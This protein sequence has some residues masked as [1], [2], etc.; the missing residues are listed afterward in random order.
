[1]TFDFCEFGETFTITGLK[2][3]IVRCTLLFRVGRYRIS[4]LDFNG[5]LFFSYER[6][7]HRYFHDSL[8][9]RGVL[10]LSGP[11]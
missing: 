8:L 4:P 7:F 10:R 6:E 3:L 2:R 1:M 11:V 9:A 5:R